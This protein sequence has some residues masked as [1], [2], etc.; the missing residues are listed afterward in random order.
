MDL[1]IF[2]LLLL[3]FTG[4]FFIPLRGKYYFTL[5]MELLLIAVTAIIALHPLT[6]GS[7]YILHAHIPFWSNVDLEVDALSAFFILLIDFTCLTSIIFAGSYLKPYYSGRLQPAWGIHFF[8]FLWLHASM[9]LLTMLRDGIAFLVVWEIM[10]L[11]SFLLVIF[12]GRKPDVLKAGLNYLVQMHI[13][14][15]F[16]LIAFVMLDGSP[17]GMNLNALGDYFHH[18]RNLG[19]FLLFFAGFGMKAGFIPLHSWLPA[20]HPAAPSHVSGVMSGVMIKIGI[21]GIIRVL[22]FVQN[23]LLIIGLTLFAVGLISALWGVMLAIMQYD[24]KRLLAYSSIENIGIIGIAM[25]LAMIGKAAGNPILE[26]LG[27]TG[28]ILHV[29][30]HSLF[31]SLLFYTAGLVYH[32]T[33][34]RNMEELGGLM[35]K[36][37][38]TALFF[39]AGSLAICALPP[40]NG[41]VSEYLV[42]VGLIK[43][44]ATHDLYVL[45]TFLAGILVLALVGGLALMAF[46]KAF[47]ITFL[48]NPRSENAAVAVE[49]GR[50]NFFVFYIITGCLFVIGLLPLLFV[51][52]LAELVQ[53]LFRVETSIPVGISTNMSSIGIIGGVFTGIIVLLWIIRN[54]RLAMVTTTKG[55]VWGC[56][57]TG[58]TG[59]MQYT[60]TS[61]VQ[62]F[63]QIA[64]PVLRFRREVRAF[65]ESEVFPES[66]TFRARWV[67]V[68]GR[69]LIE[70]PAKFL[71]YLLQKM[72]VLQ[73]G[74]LQHYILYAFLFMMLTFFLTLFN[75]I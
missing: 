33:H 63:L 55:P 21:Y 62:D 19:L 14:L 51:N 70:K 1:F 32:A 74:Q 13:G 22:T 58:D 8:S 20:A 11:S 49:N 39:L 57:Y 47:G 24:L 6:S 10:S 60:G 42:Y 16:L 68:A 18:H 45:F 64:R 28:A 53:H 25:G 65:S 12:E 46:T 50:G 34:T 37:P 59:K 31:K 5:L 48:G 38:R 52:P 36:M 69:F 23:D 2:C 17:E 35:K 43:G 15:L 73:T 7:P 27:F 9:I 75:W 71:G 61:Y 67:D 41:F 30:N 66:R 72:A 54:R 29:L 3:L 26:I 4:V 44:I 56:G 40:F